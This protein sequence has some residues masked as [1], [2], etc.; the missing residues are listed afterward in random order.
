MEWIPTHGTTSNLLLVEEM[1]ALAL[2]KMVPDI[3]DEGAERLNRFG[4][5]RDKDEKDGAEED[6]STEAPHM[7]EVEEETMDEGHDVDDED[8]DDDADEESKSHS[9]SRVHTG[10]PSFYLSLL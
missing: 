7:E 2:C 4:E 5:C 8:A 3:L 9:S 10:E 6:S 1:L